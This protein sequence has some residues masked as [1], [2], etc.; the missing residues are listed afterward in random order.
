MEIKKKISYAICSI[1][2]TG[3]YML[4]GILIEMGIGKPFE[5]LRLKFQVKFDMKKSLRKIL[6]SEM[7][8]GESANG[9]KGIKIMRLHL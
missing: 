2:R 5:N 4:C 7:K 6:L 3:S 1:P 8:K 9:I